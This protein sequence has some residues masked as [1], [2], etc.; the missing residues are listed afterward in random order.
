MKRLL[1]LNSP[2]CLFSGIGGWD[3]LLVLFVLT[4][5][6]I[7]IFWQDKMGS[8]FEYYFRSMSSYPKQIN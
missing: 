5:S 2:A 1:I 6:S 3:V 4:V 8:G 7:V